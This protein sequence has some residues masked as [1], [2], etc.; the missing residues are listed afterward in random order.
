MPDLGDSRAIGATTRT[1]FSV[2]SDFS[3]NS[4][5]SIVITI[6]DPSGEVLVDEESM[7]E[8]DAGKYQYVFDTEED[9]E[10]GV[11]R[12]VIKATSADGDVEIEEIEERFEERFE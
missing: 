9:Y 8:I 12:Y 5:E 3:I 1:R 2:F 4:V 7:N 10:D 6:I 11:Y